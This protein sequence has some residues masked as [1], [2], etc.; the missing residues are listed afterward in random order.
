MK[1][2]LSERELQAQ[3][4]LTT[5]WKERKDKKKRVPVY[6]DGDMEKGPANHIRTSTEEEDGSKVLELTGSNFSGFLSENPYGMVEFYSSR[7]M[8]SI[9]V[10]S[11]YT[12]AADIL[13]DYQ[14]RV[15]FGRVEIGLP[16][17]K[18]LMDEYGIKQVPFLVPI[19]NGARRE[20]EGE[21]NLDD[22]V[23]YMQAAVMLDKVPVGSLPRGGDEDD[24]DEDEEEGDG[25]ND[26]DEM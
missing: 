6:Q 5:M 16:G 17:N 2:Y 24:E 3:E 23:S 12:H 25:R 19:V 20:Y 15:A 7:C 22:V 11:V 13:Y 14:P 9:R 8:H 26:K 1:P 4:W 10:A 21:F 18:P